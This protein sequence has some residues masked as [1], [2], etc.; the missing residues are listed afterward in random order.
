[1]PPGASENR[2]PWQ[3]IHDPLRAQI[4]WCGSLCRWP[5]WICRGSRKAVREP[6]DAANPSATGD[7][8]PSRNLELRPNRPGNLRECAA[9]P[10]GRA[11]RSLV[12]EGLVGRRFR[13][14]A[15]MAGT[16]ATKSER[17]RRPQQSRRPKIRSERW[18][19]NR[20]LDDD[21]LEFRRGVGVTQPHVDEDAVRRFGDP[22]LPPS[23][24]A[25]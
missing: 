4:A 12:S 22:L 18:F 23:W 7:P 13:P 10:S 16:P 2:R 14:V 21:E 25:L 3:P 19:A 8:A 5:E 15:A 6:H 9:R 17:L 24:V 1:M 20:P 11:R